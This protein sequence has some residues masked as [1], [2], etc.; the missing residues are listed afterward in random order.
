MKR[1]KLTTICDL[2]IDR[3]RIK[4]GTVIGELRNGEAVSFIDGVHRG[5]IEA[6]LY[7]RVFNIEGDPESPPIPKAPAAPESPATESSEG[8]DDE[9]EG[10]G[11]VEINAS[12]NA[13]KLAEQHGIDLA[14]IEKDGQINKADV[15]AEIDARAN[16]EPAG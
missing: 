10:G 8:G 16:A 9:N 4:A 1:Q 13:R 11:D 2:V 15:Q 3:I 7:R 5:H 14:T 6:R 12:A